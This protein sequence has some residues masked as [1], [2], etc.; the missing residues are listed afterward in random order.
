MDWA[1]QVMRF[2]GSVLPTLLKRFGSER[3]GEALAVLAELYQ[4]YG[5]D[6]SAARSNIPDPSEIVARNRAKRDKQLSKK[7]KAEKT[8]QDSET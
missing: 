2:V 4:A 8:P 7:K 6:A 5:G 1:G 3:A